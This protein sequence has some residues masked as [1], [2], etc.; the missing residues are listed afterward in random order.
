VNPSPEPAGP[1]APYGPAAPAGPASAASS[2]GPVSESVPDAFPSEGS[3]AVASPDVSYGAPYGWAEPAAP[4][5]RPWGRTLTVTG[6]TVVA[7]AVAG[8]P[9]GLLWR[10]V[11]PAVPV[12]NAGEGRIL[13][14]SP[15]PEEYVAADGWFALL[16]FGFGLL[17]AIVAWMALRRDRGPFLVVGVTLGSLAAALVAWQ[18]GRL[19]GRAAWAE[20]RETSAAGATYQ[21]PPDLHAFGTL[22]VP[23]FA[24]VIVLTLLA[25]WSN[26]PNLDL[27]GAH[28]GYGHDLGR[29]P[30]GSDA[31]GFGPDGGRGGFGRGGFGSDGGPGGFG[32]DGGPG[33]SGPGGFGPDRGPGGSG[34]GGFGPDRGPGGLGPGGFGPGGGPGAGGSGVDG[35]HP[36]GSGPEGFGPDGG[37]PARRGDGGYGPGGPSGSGPVSSG[38]PGGPDPTAA[39][40]P[41]APGPAGPP[42]G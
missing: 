33:S 26:D 2:G 3:S 23:A 9:L 8:G 7:L 4:P 19:V 25:G 41:P 28:P 10:A 11:A 17:A 12:V 16:G 35:S 36:G 14:Q 15:A 27:P 42:H 39:P 34:P 37:H 24:A 22:L 20:W 18:A 38:W 13:I 29:S 32:P 31:G 21:A 40:A 30:G 6:L 1:G 5:R